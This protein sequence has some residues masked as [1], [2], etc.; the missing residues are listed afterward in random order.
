MRSGLI[1]EIV[2]MAFDT[3]RTQRLRSA[4]TILGIVIG[5]TSIVGM[6]A[7]I[8]GFD[9]SLRESIREIGP[10]TIFVVQFSGI[11][12]AAGEDFD[13]L[14][15]RPSLTPADADAIERQ[16]PSIAGVNLILGEGGP[17]TRSR[18]HYD[19]QRNPTAEHLGL[20]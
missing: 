9:E 12:L 6:T 11:S 4:L 14:L 19:G 10:D 17:P 5:I 8:R 7:I 16:A 20:H 18:L 1:R 13:E 2:S 3:V 15:R